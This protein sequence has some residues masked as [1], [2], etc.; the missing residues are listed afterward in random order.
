MIF[1]DGSTLVL[2]HLPPLTAVEAQA[3]SVNGHGGSPNGSG[4][5]I[6]RGL[7]LADVEKEY[8]RQTL[9]D[10]EGDIQRSA[11]SLGISRK[12]LWERRKR[13]GLS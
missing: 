10:L 11:E 13:H 1:A 2:D 3:P 4:F 9:E 5:H 6:A 8:I 12:S 7:T